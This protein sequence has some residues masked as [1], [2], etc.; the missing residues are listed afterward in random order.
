MCPLKCISFWLNNI[1]A[2][3]LRIRS[4]SN[5]TKCLRNCMR[6]NVGRK[7]RSCNFRNVGSHVIAWFPIPGLKNGWISYTKKDSLHISHKDI[8]FPDRSITKFYLRGRNV[9]RISIKMW[10]IKWLIFTSGDCWRIFMEEG[11]KLDTNGIKVSWQ[12]RKSSKLRKWGYKRKRSKIC[13]I[14]K[15]HNPQRKA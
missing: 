9:R 3:F 10:I 8:P 5:V 4:V 1:V 13:I 14:S 11:L 6:G 15:S 12:R 7:R 2:D